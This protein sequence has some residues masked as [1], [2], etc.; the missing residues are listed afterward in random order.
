[1]LNN[2]NQLRAFFLAAREKN[3]TRAAESL[4]VTQPA[5]TMQ[6]KSLE[7]ALG[8]KLIQKCGSDFHLTEVGNVLFRY[9]ERIFGIVEE[10]EYAL[11]GYTELAQ[12]S[13]KLGT[14]RSF[15]RYFMPDLISRY[16]DLYPKVKVFLK[17][18]NS[19]EILDGIMSFEYDLG[20]IGGLPYGKRIKSIS[21]TRPE[22]W[23]VAPP[24]HRF[25]KK[26]EIS[27]QDLQNEPIII[28]EKGS[29]ARH[30][31]LSLLQ[32]QGVNPSVLVE[33]GSVEFIKE[34]VLQGEGIAFLYKAEV[35][36]EVNMGLL[37]GLK[38]KE[39]PV[40]LQTDI[41]Y[42]KDV[43]L[44]PPSQAFLRLTEEMPKYPID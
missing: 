4:C 12:G 43:E 38:I 21:Y 28:R 37:L 42:L 20:L 36:R 3:L 27:L 15:A 24:N 13:L 35:E 31:I 39:G 11:K 8:M 6:I 22:F 5:V 10:M 23:L 18:G 30:M 25:I 34:Y 2:L 1:M 41:V 44:S 26:T 16:Q 19:Q 32:S 17:E 9:L 40:F 7:H 29:G 33:A 14:T